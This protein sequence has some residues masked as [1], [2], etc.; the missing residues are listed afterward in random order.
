[1]LR[2]SRKILCL[3]LLN[4]YVFNNSSN[5]SFSSFIKGMFSSNENT[6]EE[7]VLSKDNKP[8][9]LKVPVSSYILKQIK[10]INNVDIKNKKDSRIKDDNFNT[11]LTQQQ[12]MLGILKDYSYNIGVFNKCLITVSQIISKIDLYNILFK[13]KDGL[14]KL[15]MELNSILEKPYQDELMNL[16]QIF[17]KI[18]DII[19][20]IKL[21]FQEKDGLINKMMLLDNTVSLNEN[22]IKSMLSNCINT[23]YVFVNEDIVKYYTN[24]LVEVDA[25]MRN[26]KLMLPSQVLFIL[27]YYIRDEL[28]NKNNELY[29]TYI[30]FKNK[31]TLINQKLTSINDYVKDNIQELEGSNNINSKVNN[32]EIIAVA[33]NMGIKELNRTNNDVIDEIE[34]I[35]TLVNNVIGLLNVFKNYVPDEK[36][37]TA[38]EQSKTDE[39]SKNTEKQNK[40]AKKESADDEKS[41]NKKEQVKKKDTA[42]AK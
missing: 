6:N 8:V 40:Q 5:A 14:S 31:I 37:L 12:Q 24:I 29:E 21:L 28:F 13:Q 16:N 27:F 32:E 23:I 22:E 38:I 30:A 9:E 39:K 36:I 26:K 4:I 41:G 7:Q 25:K 2:I 17:N 3:I 11:I 42:K 19:N 34:Q 15:I 18:L 20:F 10:E 1:M 35:R 33:I